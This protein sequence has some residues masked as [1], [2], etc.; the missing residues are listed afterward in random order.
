MGNEG[1]ITWANGEPV[2]V[3][4]WAMSLYGPARIDAIVLD[5]DG[6][7]LLSRPSRADGVNIYPTNEMWLIDEGSYG[8]FPT[9]PS[10]KKRLETWDVDESARKVPGVRYYRERVSR[11]AWPAVERTVDVPTLAQSDV[12]RMFARN[13]RH[14]A[15]NRIPDDS[16]ERMTDHDINYVYDALQEVAWTLDKMAEGENA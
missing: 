13:L 15:D 5:E 16:S 11:I 3:G 10:D 8:D 4:Q 1:C 14:I 7:T 6:W 9:H 2:I 12:L